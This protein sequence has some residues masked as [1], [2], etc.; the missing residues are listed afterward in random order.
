MLTRFATEGLMNPKT[1]MDFRMK[2]LEPG[3]SRD[4]AD[5]VRDFLGRPHTFAAYETWLKK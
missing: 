4:A 1:A 5:M 3:G 2:V